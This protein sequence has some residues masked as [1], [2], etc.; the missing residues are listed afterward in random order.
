MTAAALPLRRSWL[1]QALKQ[2]ESNSTFLSI[3]RALAPAKARQERG[4]SPLRIYSVLTDHLSTLIPLYQPDID[5]EYDELGRDEAE[6]ALEYG[7][8]VEFWGF[9]DYSVIQDA[10]THPAYALI[11]Y[12]LPCYEGRTQ[13]DEPY[14]L[15]SHLTHLPNALVSFKNL[16]HLPEGSGSIGHT[17]PPRGRQWR[18]AWTGLPDLYA[19]VTHRTGCAILDWTQEDVYENGDL[20]EWNLDEVKGLISDWKYGQPV[21]KRVET[22]RDYIGH[23]ATRL[24]QLGRL[25]TGAPDVRQHLSEP[26]RPGK[27]LAQIFMGARHA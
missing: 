22:L 8:P 9:E 17:K 23:D 26:K 14:K 24:L 5:A 10:A 13:D 1:A 21:W 15:D 4:E 12:L 16:A 3:L 7:I 27:T 6:I 20:P 19:Y 25:L 2:Y 11:Y 18:G